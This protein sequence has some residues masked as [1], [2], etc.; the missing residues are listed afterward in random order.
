M[1]HPHRLTSVASV[2]AFALAG[3]AT[4]TL[5]S[6]ASGTRFTYRI[7][8]KRGQSPAD[9]PLFVGVLTGPENES[10]YD[11]LGTI[12]PDGRTTVPPYRHGM[13]SRISREA[14]SAKAFAWFWRAT[15]AG[16]VPE[17]VEVWHEGKCGRCGRKLT[18]PE[19]IEAGIGPEC[20]QL[21]G[22]SQLVLGQRGL[23]GMLQRQAQ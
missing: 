14:P 12:F 3:N 9:T 2:R 18:V 4:L 8:V 21:M 17:S 20:A 1:T 6:R 23:S 19:S 22:Y 11:F 10:H 5:L 16:H 13:R 15:E 7:R